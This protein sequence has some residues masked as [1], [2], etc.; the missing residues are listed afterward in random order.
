MIS[1]ADSSTSTVNNI[2]ISFPD[3]SAVDTLTHVG[4]ITDEGSKHN[5]SL[6]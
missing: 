6:I 2:G 1:M 3:A 4:L 5:Y